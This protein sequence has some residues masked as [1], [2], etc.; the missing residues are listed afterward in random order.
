MRPSRSLYGSGRRM[1][2]V[3]GPTHHGMAFVDSRL[4]EKLAPG[5]LPQ[6]TH[7]RGSVATGPVETG[8]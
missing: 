6:I 5:A 1:M 8:G 2:V 3:A 4:A 7:E